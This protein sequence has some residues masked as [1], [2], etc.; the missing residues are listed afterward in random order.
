MKSNHQNQK[1]TTTTQPQKPRGIGRYTEEFA[2]LICQRIANTP[3]GLAKICESADMPSTA[4]IYRWLREHDEFGYLY[5]EAKLIQADYLADEI[6][7]LA[8]DTSEDNIVT[9]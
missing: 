8:D 7:A 4:T 1:Y 3:R 9:P 6:I 2:F 5:E